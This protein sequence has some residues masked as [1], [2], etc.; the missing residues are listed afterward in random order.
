MQ[1]P[2]KAQ[3]ILTNAEVSILHKN[4]LRLLVSLSLAILE[5]DHDEGF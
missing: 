1:R 4:P 2:M 3:K 5:G